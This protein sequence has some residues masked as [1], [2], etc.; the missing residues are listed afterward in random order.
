MLSTGTLTAIYI[1]GCPP[2]KTRQCTKKDAVAILTNT[3]KQA[4]ALCMD[5]ILVTYFDNILLEHHTCDQFAKLNKSALKCS[6]TD[7]YILH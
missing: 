6:E 2:L 3:T 4:S 1:V 7:K 5:N